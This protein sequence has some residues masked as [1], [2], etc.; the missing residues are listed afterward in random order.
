MLLK[1]LE[2]INIMGIG[3]C[4]KRTIIGV[5]S[6]LLCM[7][8]VGCGTENEGSAPVV[9][10]DGS[11]DV[12]AEGSNSAYELASDSDSFFPYGEAFYDGRW[13]N[14]ELGKPEAAV[15]AADIYANVKYTEQMF[16]GDYRLN[17][18]N[19]G[20]QTAYASKQFLDT[21]AWKQ[22][23]EVS[24]N[25]A[26]RVISAI[27]YR[28]V[29]GDAEYDLPLALNKDYNWCQVFFAENG[30]N[31]GAYID[32]TYEVDGNVITFTPVLSWN[33]NEGTGD[34]A[35]EL[36]EKSI[37]YSFEFC[38]PKVT[39]SDGNS[40][41]TLIERDFT[42]WLS[43]VTED[44]LSV[45]S[46]LSENSRMIDDISG[47]DMTVSMDGE[48]NIDMK[49]CE[50][51]LRT[52]D[53]SGS[54][55][56]QSGVA[57]WD[58]DGLF[59][60]TYENEA[61]ELVTHQVVMFYCG[62]DGVILSDGKKNYFYLSTYLSEASSGRYSIE[63]L[64]INV[65]EETQELIA[66]LTDEEIEEIIETKDNLLEDLERT[67]SE[68]GIVAEVDNTT[69]KIILDSSIL[70]ASGKSDLSGDAK[71][72]LNDFI[73]ALSSVIGDEKYD[74]FISKIEIQGHTNTDG[75]Y[76]AHKIL[77]QERADSVRDYSLSIESLDA[78]TK[79]KLE[80]IFVPVGYSHDYPIY[81]EDGSVNMAASRRVEFVFYISL[82]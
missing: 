70:F 30:S 45:S 20:V 60:F 55:H 48:G 73:I 61:G 17:H 25:L 78:A 36:E 18:P 76:E 41:Y 23:A 69:G 12:L 49:K 59:T 74:G 54:E 65:S 19:D 27:P 38:G 26:G 15:S 63:D 42:R 13:C 77:S 37:S 62:F 56:K 33:Y 72:F 2:V 51:S 1:I 52:V 31:T 67:F 81:N 66:E 3:A 47:I 34:L 71:A 14:I 24:A 32:A 53:A 4:V 6:I 9:V 44:S 82:I 11:S 22:G 29:A 40:S 79:A 5:T 7:G 28:I 8:V 21:C 80:S 58:E 50:F 64:G 75:E 46:K 57:K 39:L 10:Q 43:Y 35:F 68:N 16:F